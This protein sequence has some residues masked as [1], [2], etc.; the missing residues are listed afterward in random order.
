MV[1]S[2]VKN[3]MVTNNT[4]INNMVRIEEETMKKVLEQLNMTKRMKV[5]E[6][7]S[8]TIEEVKLVKMISKRRR[9]CMV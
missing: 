4:V 7:I 3:H 6:E 2:M 1:I 9:K 5:G 8:K